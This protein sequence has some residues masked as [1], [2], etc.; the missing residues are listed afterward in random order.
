M[1]KVIYFIFLFIFFVI[2][3]GC[4][5]ICVNTK[6]SFIDT[7][8]SV[9]ISGFVVQHP[10]LLRNGNYQFSSGEIEKLQKI[11]ETSRCFKYYFLIPGSRDLNA[12]MKTQ[13][14]MVKLR[15][16]RNV[17]VDITNKRVYEP[18]N[19]S[20]MEW[21]SNLIDSIDYLDHN[22]VPSDC[23]SEGY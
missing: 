12:E 3:Y 17:L 15:I 11:V 14:G 6:T 4:V 5:N 8:H 23:K 2:A 18:Q 21:L 7:I 19:K 9:S 22:L 16:S 13:K 20:D 1:S 10:Q